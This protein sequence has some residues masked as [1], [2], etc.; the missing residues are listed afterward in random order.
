MA[1]HR[2][3]LPYFLGHELIVLGDL[4]SQCCQQ[5]Y[6][7]SQHHCLFHPFRLSLPAPLPILDDSKEVTTHRCEDIL[8]LLWR[9]CSGGVSRPLR[10]SS[11]LPSESRRD[12]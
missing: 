7:N 12:P 1:C 10:K 11:R 2:V 3:M 6:R 8:N 5:H 4:P 9:G